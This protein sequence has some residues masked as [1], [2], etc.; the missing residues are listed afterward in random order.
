MQGSGKKKELRNILLFRK[1]PED[2]VT[3]MKECVKKE[4]EQ[5]PTKEE[6]ESPDNGDPKMTSVRQA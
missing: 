6:N 4:D 1:L 2:V 5:D 3:R